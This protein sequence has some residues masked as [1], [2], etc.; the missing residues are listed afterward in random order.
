MLKL[1]CERR[2]SRQTR[3]KDEVPTVDFETLRRRIRLEVVRTKVAR[4]EVPWGDPFQ[5]VHPVIQTI[6]RPLL[7]RM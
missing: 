4:R 2:Q 7:L 3:P 1:D 6:L 5:L